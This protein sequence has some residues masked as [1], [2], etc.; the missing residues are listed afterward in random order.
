MEVSSMS[1]N[2]PGKHDP[3]G[4]KRVF[5][6]TDL[7][8][9]I[10]LVFLYSF[11]RVF[12]RLVWIK[13]S[14]AIDAVMAIGLQLLALMPAL[15]GLKLRLMIGKKLKEGE[16]SSSFAAGLSFG[17]VIPLMTAYLVFIELLLVVPR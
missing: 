1:E 2:E 10:L 17:L 12:I 5:V 7:M 13:P 6:L 16:I 15:G 8:F 14:H 9:L 11:E 3:I 4:N